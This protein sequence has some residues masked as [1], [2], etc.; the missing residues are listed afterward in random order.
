MQVKDTFFSRKLTINCRGELLDLSVPR[1]MGIL[2]ITPDS[3][4]DGGKYSDPMH[5][6]GRVEQMFNEGCDIL[7]IG[8]YSSR[9]GAKNISEKEEIER[10][11]LVLEGIRKHFPDAI[12]SV[13]T[14]RAGVAE[15]VI[16]HF[17][18][19]IINDISGGD[20]D[21]QMFEVISKYQVPYILMHMQGTP[22]NMQHNPQ[23]ENVMKEISGYFAQKVEQLKRMGVHDVILDPGFGFGKTIEHNYQILKYFSDFRIFELPILAGLSRKSMIYKVLDTNPNNALNGTSV[24]NTLALLGGANI[25]RVHDIKEAKETLLLTRK[26]LSATVDQWHQ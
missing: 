18:A 24:L 4:Y 13:D 23:Y 10:L 20:M 12:L 14:F 9:P 15:H 7:D 3:F 26:Y 22:E 21:P 25:L 19:D 17:E 11:S 2:N 5:I 6:I 8:A 16:Q 1:I